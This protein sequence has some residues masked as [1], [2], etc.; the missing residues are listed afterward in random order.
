MADAASRP[1][2]QVFYGWFVV[3]AAFA[4][5]LVGFGS[6]YAFSAF[7]EPLQREFS[8]SRGSVALVFSIAGFLYFGLGIVSGP[9]ADR[10]GSRT[11]AAIGM[12]LV[13]VG[14]ALAGMARTLTEV[15]LAYG[16]GV[17]IGV[18]LSYVPAVGAVQR[19]FVRRR[20]FASGLAVSGIGVGTL[21][22]PPVAALM[23]S[24]LGW[25][26]AYLL[27]GALAAVIGAGMALLISNDPRERGLAPDGDTV[28]P[29][30]QALQASGASLAEAIRTPRFIGLYVAG[31]LASFGVFVPFVHL[32]PYA[33]DRGIAPSAAVI[34]LGA[35]GVGST[36]GRFFLGSLADRFG[37][38]ASLI[39][40][41]IGMGLALATWPLS[42]AFW[43]LAVF[44]LVFGTFYGGWVALLPAVLMDN[45]GGRNVSAIIGALYTSV[46]FGT[47]TGPTLA[48]FVFDLAGSYTWPIVASA[49]ANILAAAILART[50][51]SA[52][53]A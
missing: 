2:P 31:L 5:T 19:W 17:G 32:V 28:V 48:G 46:A 53:P 16:L 22:M 7:F 18:G 39:A 34:L 13:G 4:V 49:G 9:L 47:L 24:A 26:G 14:M 45:F 33:V 27:L 41:F 51:R 15:Y 35:I 6:A 50:I 8:A 52:R 44:A 23:I 21:V 3:A 12:V 25:R 10:F 29:E 37:R 38:N 36:A 11:M 30:Q 42:S 1:A 20:G 43:Q 40:M